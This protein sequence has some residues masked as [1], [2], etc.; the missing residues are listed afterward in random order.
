MPAGTTEFIDITTADVFIPEVWS[1]FA[2]VQSEQPRVFA[3][4]VN[5]RFEEGLTVGD[6]VR[7][8]SIGNLT[9]RTKTANTAITYETVTEVGVNITIATDEY[10][11]MAVESIIKVQADRDLFTAYAG[12][13]GYALGLSVD[14]VLAGLPD[15][16]TNAVGALA[17]T[18]SLSDW[19]RCIQYLDDEN[20][21]A[22]NRQF[23][24]AP[25]LRAAL[26]EMDHYI[27]N[28]YSALHGP[29]PKVTALESAYQTSFLGQ[30]VYI[31]SN[32]EGSNAAGHD[33][34]FFHKEAF[35]LVMQM[36]PTTTFQYDIDYLVDK[37]AMENIYGNRTMR[38]S[39]TYG[40]YAVF[41]RGP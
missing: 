39:A 12:K 24:V 40:R 18:P 29:G 2:L 26:L 28:D 7:V 22:A 38:D 10:A 37:V 5:R 36:Q 16:Q 41:F 13:L 31:T 15:D 1:S 4:L 27:H 20:V 3:G 32:V 30:P 14:D 19:I 34:V 11:A 33:N 9:A 21:P 35:A 25:A 23:I 17:V 8:P 6:L